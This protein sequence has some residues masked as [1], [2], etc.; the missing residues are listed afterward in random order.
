[1][2]RFAWM[3]IAAVLVI[4]PCFYLVPQ[5]WRD[6][7]IWHASAL[8]LLYAAIVELRQEQIDEKNPATP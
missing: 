6:D 1:M 8:A 5:R 7:F 4:D 2:R 3:L